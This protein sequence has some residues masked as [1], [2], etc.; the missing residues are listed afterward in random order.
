MPVSACMRP[1]PSRPNPLTGSPLDRVSDLRGD[2]A[3]VAA[4]LAGP[5]SLFLP[6]RG[7]ESLL[8]ENLQ[9]HPEPL[10]LGYQAVADLIES[11]PWAFLGQWENRATFTLD[12]G[13]TLDVPPAL[14]PPG[15]RFADLRSV[16]TALDP[17]DAAILAHA[18]GLLHWRTRHRF[19]GVCGAATAP[20]EAGNRVI[21]TACGTEHFPRTDPAVIMLVTDGD[22]ALLGHARRFPNTTLFS[23]LAGFVEPGE[24]LE[25]A[26]AREVHEEVG[27]RV[28]DVH[29]H[30]SQPWPFPGSLMLGFWAQAQSR[31]ITVDAHEILEARWFTRAEL[32]AHEALG[33]SLPGPISIARRLIEDWMNA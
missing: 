15:A 5:D 24:S 25:E 28:S 10:A 23:T 7:P 31:A 2:P 9:G 27:I 29:Y 19:C 1:F 32:R 8:V 16:A 17:P 30:S 33:F 3:W 21:C 14:I 13:T 12:L 18:R 26:V 6:F 11:T 4:R 20:A 22:A